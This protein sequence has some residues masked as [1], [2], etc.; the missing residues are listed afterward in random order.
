MRRQNARVC[1]S[2]KGRGFGEREFETIGRLIADVVEGM[3]HNG[4]EGDAQVEE[5]VRG[6][7]AALCAA[8]P[9]YPE[10]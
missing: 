2:G 4:A 3:A 1:G 9:I 6:E 5:R 7:V 8:H 10:M